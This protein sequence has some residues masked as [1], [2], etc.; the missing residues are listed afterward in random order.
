MPTSLPSA[1]S[2]SDV[3]LSPRSRSAVCSSAARWMIRSSAA[4]SMRATEPSAMLLLLGGPSGLQAELG[5]QG[6]D[7][8]RGQ[9][10][11]RCLGRTFGAGRLGRPGKEGTKEL[12]RNREDGGGVVLRRDFGDRLEI[13]ELE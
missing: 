8:G 6:G 7:V 9:G 12:H 11:A 2:S 1:I 4:R 13:A 3:R 5:H 10:G